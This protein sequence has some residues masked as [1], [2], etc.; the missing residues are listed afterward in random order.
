MTP[1]SLET[2]EVIR[3]IAGCEVPGAPSHSIIRSGSR[4]AG[5]SCC[6]RKSGTIATPATTRS[7]TVKYANLEF[8][9][10][11]LSIPSKPLRSQTKNGD[12]RSSEACDK[13]TIPSAGVTVRATAMLARTAST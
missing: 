13:S 1:I 12:S 4:K 5:R 3:T 10:M 11:P 2:S 9:T 6:W 8:E 7:A